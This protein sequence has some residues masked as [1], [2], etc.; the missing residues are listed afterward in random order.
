MNKSTNKVV[1]ALSDSKSFKAGDNQ[2][3]EDITLFQ[4]LFVSNHSVMLMIDPEKGSILHA[5][6]AAAT[7]YGW[8]QEDL[9]LKNI[10]DINTLSYEEILE[11]MNTARV[12][13][14]RYF[15]FR[16]R[17]ANGTIRDVEVF[18][19]PVEFNGRILLYSIIK[20]ITDQ[21]K[22]EEEIRN[23]NVNLE[24]NI[25]LRTAELEKTNFNL[26][27]EIEER[28]RVEEALQE[29]ELSYKTV[30]ENVKE[31]IFKT[32][33][34][35]LW[36]FLNKSWEEI[37]GFSVEESIGKL[38]VN[39]VHPDDR[40]RNMELFK[41]LIM[42][43]KD[44]CR[45]VVR[46]LTKD[47]GFK[48]IEVFARLG[49][50]ENDE[51][52]GTYGTL[53]DITDRKLGEESLSQIRTNYET[54]FNTIDDFLFVLDEQGN[55]IHINDTVRQRLG[56]SEEEL[57]D[58]SVLMCHPAE[59]REEAGRIVGEMLAGTA[60]FCP[61]PLI[62]NSG[63]YI[64]VET[65]ISR[66]HWDG[67]PAIFGVSKDVAKIKVSEEKF[68]TAFQ[69]NPSIMAISDFETGVFIDVNASFLNTFG[70]LREE[71]IG[72]S[73]I[74]LNLFEAPK[75]REVLYRKLK[76]NI[77]V[78]DVEI[79]ALTKSGDVRIGL[80][81][82]HPIVVGSEVCL[83]TVMVD[84][85][86]RKKAEAEVLKARHEAEQANLAKSEFLSRMS[87]ELRTP[88]NSILGFAQL[89]EM[90]DITSSQRK[91][92][93]HILKSGNHLLNLINEVLDITRIEAGKLS[94]KMEPI[95]LQSVIR[96]MIDIVQPKAQK[97]N[98]KLIFTNTPS[99]KMFVVGD[100]Q[101]VKQVLLNLLTNALKY[102]REYG[103]VTI[104]MQPIPI[105]ELGLA[106]IR[107]TVSDTGIG[108]KPE[109]FSKLFTPY[110]RIA[111]EESGTEGTGLGLPI[112]KKLMD[113]MGGLIG[114]HS[115][116]GKGS[117]FWIE[118]PASDAIEVGD[119]VLQ[120][121]N[122]LQPVNSNR[123][124]T[125]LYIEDN[126]SNVE[127]V[128]DILENHRPG[129]TLVNSQYGRKTIDLVLQHSPQLILLD[130]D[131]PDIHGEEVLADLLADAN[132]TKVP[133]IVL[134][135]DARPEQI[136]AL[137]K[138]GASHYLTKPIEIMAFLSLIDKLL[139]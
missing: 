10:A 72:K 103:S 75:M 2:G 57:I 99:D 107:I 105:S 64:P 29:S 120:L 38:F 54:F 104:K 3:F 119:E 44:Y 16:H 32:D 97:M 70:Y 109:D 76:H 46:Y 25:L 45:H 91:G 59:R 55:I 96:E 132:L 87:H 92:V 86:E 51:I 6:K 26:Q 101:C 134:S 108:I 125:I 39:Y 61:V 56:Y 50:N 62:T 9:C 27:L 79:D 40:D 35:G 49:L 12:E 77:P 124:S 41:P 20:D 68:S 13:N 102:N 129:I 63:D 67:K 137:L 74:D 8:S 43:Q 133:V 139:K 117:D 127:L 71:I 135:A 128:A 88:M 89:L 136:A 28:K 15:Q 36:V 82:A 73:S 113:A 52:T 23:L 121:N 126:H 21:L 138:S 7:Y 84:I 123:K 1:Q 66:G 14:R 80:F 90:D 65:R 53:Q 22:S 69:S 111:P 115:I 130:L 110:E 81:S 112:T 19:G 106:K 42:R 118:L 85:T 83:L 37:S 98:M 100:L 47:G 131:L 4:S 78:K 94:L 17:L 48:W 24:K 33:T 11:E 116:P 58:K 5:N 30:V 60:D 34:E 18:S 114:F 95:A 122:E 31:I 93:S